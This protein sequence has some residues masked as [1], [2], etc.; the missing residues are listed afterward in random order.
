M[1][2][3][4]CVWQNKWGCSFVADRTEFDTKAKESV[5]MSQEDA[6]RPACSTIKYVLVS[7]T[8]VDPYERQHSPVLRAWNLFVSEWLLIFDFSSLD[9]LENQP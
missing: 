7:C 3:F 5:A 6:A 2:Q 4:L 8:C 9:G 1:I